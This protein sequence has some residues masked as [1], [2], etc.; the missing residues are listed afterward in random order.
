MM[1]ETSVTVEETIEFDDS[2]L[3]L[4]NSTKHFYEPPAETIRL[5]K[6]ESQLIMHQPV[7]NLLDTEDAGRYEPDILSF[8]RPRFMIEKDELTIEQ[9][10][11]ESSVLH[12]PVLKIEEFEEHRIET[13]IEDEL[14]DEID[15]VKANQIELNDDCNQ[16]V[17]IIHKTKYNLA[18]IN[19]SLDREEYL[20]ENKEQ[21]SL[22]TLY[23]N[24][25]ESLNINLNSFAHGSKDITKNIIDR[26]ALSREVIEIS[27]QN[28]DICEEIMHKDTAQLYQSGNYLIEET[29]SETINIIDKNRHIHS[30]AN[31][32]EMGL[33]ECEGFELD[34]LEYSKP[35]FTHQ[36]NVPIESSYTSTKTIVLKN[37]N[38]VEIEFKFRD[39]DIFESSEP[40]DES[41][42]FINNETIELNSIERVEQ[43]RPFSLPAETL[44]EETSE[45][46]HEFSEASLAETPFV[47]REEIE[48]TETVSVNKPV[49]FYM[50][51][52]EIKIEEE[53]NESTDEIGDFKSM[54]IEQVDYVKEV[55]S[56]TQKPDKQLLLWLNYPQVSS[57]LNELDDETRSID[58][59]LDYLYE[60]IRLDRHSDANLESDSNIIQIEKVLSFFIS[61]QEQLES[62]EEILKN[63]PQSRPELHQLLMNN[64]TTVE[65][66]NSLIINSAP[67][68]LQNPM[69]RSDL[70]Y[71]DDSIEE[72]VEERVNTAT[73]NICSEEDYLELANKSDDLKLFSLPL[74]RQSSFKSEKIDFIKATIESHEI[75]ENMGSDSAEGFYQ[76]Q[77]TKTTIFNA[78][79][80]SSQP[81]MDETWELIPDVEQQN[82]TLTHTSKIVNRLTSQEEPFYW[83]NLNYNE[84]SAEDSFDE[85]RPV[86]ETVKEVYFKS[87]TQQ[88]ILHGEHA[89]RISTSAEWTREMNFIEPRTSSSMELDNIERVNQVNY[90]IDSKSISYADEEALDYLVVNEMKE[91]DLANLKTNNETGSYQNAIEFF[92]P[93]NT[94]DETTLSINSDEDLG[95]FIEQV[96][97]YEIISADSM[98]SQADLADSPTTFNRASVHHAVEE[99]RAIMLSESQAEAAQTQ[100]FSVERDSLKRLVEQIETSKW[101]Q[102]SALDEDNYINEHL[103]STN[104]TTVHKKECFRPIEIKIQRTNNP[105]TD[106]LSE[107]ETTSTSDSSST[108]GNVHLIESVEVVT[109]HQGDSCSQIVDNLAHDVH[110]HKVDINRLRIKEKTCKSSENAD[111]NDTRYKVNFK[112]EELVDLRGQDEST[113]RMDLTTD[114]VF[115]KN[116]A[117][118]ISKLS[119]SKIV[120]IEQNRFI[121]SE[122]SLDNTLNDESIHKYE[123]LNF[124]KIS[125]KSTSEILESLSHL[126]T[127]I[128]K[129]LTD[130]VIEK[131]D[132]NAN[133]NE[134]SFKSKNEMY[135]FD[136]NDILLSEPPCNVNINY[137]DEGSLK[138]AQEEFFENFS[139]RLH[140]SSNYDNNSMYE[141]YEEG[142]ETEFDPNTY[143]IP[144]S[145]EDLN[146]S[147]LSFKEVIIQTQKI[148]H[149][150]HEQQEKR[151]VSYSSITPTNIVDINRPPAKVRFVPKRI[152]LEF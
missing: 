43:T 145:L 144:V 152:R 12:A 121:D 105:E 24:A 3:N 44:N 51:E 82:A 128:G 129:H 13:F 136:S 96:E 79:S 9:R 91:E 89:D 132:S 11:G 14:V 101:E 56:L 20:K 125:T 48:I 17:G 76:S 70:L 10:I 62:H 87:I 77:H 28:A 138:E 32:N 102:P 47:A 18:H 151:F 81:K 36:V 94:T 7:I 146:N 26:Y 78:P 52:S 64:Q 143:K 29:T 19:E 97:K 68:E 116:F 65:L 6:L 5:S 133:Q 148:E 69:E 58:D 72:Y 134:T 109:H 34:E 37:P 98:L 103:T 118:Q 66:E 8:E 135:F 104:Y 1:N 46:I 112:Q 54:R 61:N 113:E 85:Q 147:S 119:S 111:E 150:F 93:M 35:S 120:D 30:L 100:L 106:S 124:N 115:A 141:K 42:A 50:K 86:E 21:N 73:S 2:S 31:L 139:N 122:D 59:Q 127:D 55:T 23:E 80:S 49:R 83:E 71:E 15:I 88:E 41:K 95:S 45:D 22:R 92:D 137:D 4:I 67:L 39:A 40:F 117:Q 16:K 126:K 33:E 110:I 90:N 63:L 38:S 140:S 108:S 27:N 60:K 75:I 123:H 130:S 149:S 74:Q 131:C 107:N 25:N 53:L 57:Q 99:E 84:K 142:I 114:K